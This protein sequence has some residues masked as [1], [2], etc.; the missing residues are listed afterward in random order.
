M[1][2]SVIGDW[3]LTKSENFDELMR[4]MGVEL[5]MRMLA[6]TTE[7]SVKFEKNGDEWTFTTSS[8][9][10]TTEVKFM[11]NEEFDEKA[12]DDRK[13]KVRKFDNFYG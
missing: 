1:D 7:P 6:R 12:A 2:V 3:K 8:A 11:L 9:V 5:V 4:K 13:V 10:G